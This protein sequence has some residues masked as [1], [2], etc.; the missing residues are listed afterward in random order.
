[1]DATLLP[2]MIKAIVFDFFDVFRTDTYKAWLAR[3]DFPNIHEYAA[4]SRQLD[5]GEISSEAFLQRLSD[6]S[7]QAVTWESLDA[8]ATMNADVIAIAETLGSQH[9][10]ALLSNAPSALLRDILVQHDL[11]RL[12][13]HVVIS[14]EV[15][16]AKPD[17]AIFHFVLDRLGT[18][19]HETIF[20]DDNETH[21]QAARAIGIHGIQFISARQLQEQLRKIN[22]I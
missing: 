1:M 17:S 22:V 5:M 6:L 7:G 9:S 2:I 15:G 13:D 8:E 16:L 12:F 19:P 3:N 18:E 10:I 21:V 14:S 4:A 11:E 20:I